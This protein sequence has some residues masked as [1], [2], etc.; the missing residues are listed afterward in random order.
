MSRFYIAVRFVAI[1]LVALVILASPSYSQGRAPSGTIRLEI[2][3]G[4]FIIGGSAG[5]G[6][7][8]YQGKQYPV[9]VG[10]LSIGLTIGA[11]KTELI[12][13]VYN[14]TN[15]SDIAGT[16]TAGEAGLSVAGGKKIARLRNSKGVFLR[17][18]GRQIGLEATLDLSGMEIWLK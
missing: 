15:V 14:L 4:G 3:S 5:S 2:V 11:A 17:L 18:R 9:G 12:G 6:T 16:Y 10:G 8:T 1:S 7:L 13:R